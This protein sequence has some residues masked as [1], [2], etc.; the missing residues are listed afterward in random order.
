MVIKIFKQDKKKT[1]NAV[2][3]NIVRN[4]NNLYFREVSFT[5]HLIFFLGYR[6]TKVEIYLYGC[7]FFVNSFE[8]SINALSKSYSLN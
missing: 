4:K 3:N 1:A 6:D 7:I 5:E 8:Q 2:V